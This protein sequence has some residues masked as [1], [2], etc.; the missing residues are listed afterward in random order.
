MHKSSLNLHPQQSPL[1]MANAPVWQQLPMPQ[2]CQC[3][4]VLT[5][6]LIAVSQNEPSEEKRHE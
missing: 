5:Q 6:L 3:H 4:E 1:P 2:R